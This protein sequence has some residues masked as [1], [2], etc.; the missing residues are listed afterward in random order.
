MRTKGASAVTGDSNGC[1]LERSNCTIDNPLYPQDGV[2]SDCI[3]CSNQIAE[4]QLDLFNSSGLSTNIL[5]VA[6]AYGINEFI[7]SALISK[8]TNVGEDLDAG[9]FV[10][11]SSPDGCYGVMRVPIEQFNKS[12]DPTVDGP[13]SEAAIIAGVELLFAAA[14]CV[15]QNTIMS[16]RRTVEDIIMISK[17]AARNAIFFI[18]FSR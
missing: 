11:C 18:I 12:G 10:P 14:E 13:Y 8:L 15:C 5:Y 6:Q 2:E 9:G 17:S 1:S 3:D 7:I 16:M 4:S